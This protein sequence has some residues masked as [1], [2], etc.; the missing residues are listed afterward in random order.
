MVDRDPVE[1]GLEIQFHLAHEVPGEA[2][3]VSHLG[4]VLW[5]HDEAKLMAIFPATLHKGL[6][7]G[8]VLKSG[9]GLAPIA[10]T[11]NTIPFKVT[12]M[13]IDGSAHRPAHLRTPRALSLWID[14]DHPGLDH[15]PS[16]A[17]ATGRISL[18]RTIAALLSK[19]G[20]GL[21]APAARVEPARPASFPAIGRARSR[22]YPPRIGACLAH[23]DLN[24]LEERL[25]P[26]IEPRS[27][28]VGPPRPDPKILTLIPRHSETIDMEMSPHKSTQQR[29]L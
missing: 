26:R 10:V 21:C 4:C 8:F 29:S 9:I 11:R 16:R 15:H 7:A 13:G 25:R 5:R 12:Q 14:P 17:E 22:A 1:A 18:P 23:R 3:K 28:S 6:A 27:T 19:R 2:A 20:N 24:L